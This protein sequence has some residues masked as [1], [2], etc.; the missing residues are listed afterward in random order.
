MDQYI[1]KPTRLQCTDEGMANELSLLCPGNHYHLSLEGSSPGVGNRA[2]ASAIYQG[3]FCSYIVQEIINIFIYQEHEQTVMTHERI[4]AGNNTQVITTPMR[5]HFLRSLTSRTCQ[6]FGLTH[7]LL[8]KI[9]MLKFENAV[10]SFNVWLI[11]IAKLQRGRSR[12]CTAIWAIHATG[13]SS[14]C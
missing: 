14:G 2:A 13:S 9:N 4:H 7:H 8:N 1:K 6:R 5:P 11:V 3:V 10:E 12:S